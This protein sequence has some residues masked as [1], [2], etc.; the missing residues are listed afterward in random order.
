MHADNHYLDASI[1][2]N[3]AHRIRPEKLVDGL[4]DIGLIVVLINVI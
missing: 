2:E 1:S 3:G 4:I